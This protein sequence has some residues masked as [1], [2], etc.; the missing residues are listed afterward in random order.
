MLSQPPLRAKATLSDQYRRNRRSPGGSIAG[1]SLSVA[2]TAPVSQLSS[3]PQ[4][5]IRELPRVL[6]VQP[7]LGEH[8]RAALER[9]SVACYGDHRAEIGRR[10]LQHLVMRQGFRLAVA[11]VRVARRPDGGRD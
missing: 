6:V 9:R 5:E 3:R 4:Q 10:D 11:A 7:R 8:A 2:A 1:S